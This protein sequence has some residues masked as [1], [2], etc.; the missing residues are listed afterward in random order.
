MRRTRKVTPEGML[1]KLLMS[2]NGL[3]AKELACRIGKAEATVCD[4]I[5]GKNKSRKTLNLILDV[6]REEQESEKMKEFL[7]LF[8]EQFGE[9]DI[10]DAFEETDAS[11]EPVV[12]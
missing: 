8:K 2:T 3:T 5:S 9:T 10:L 12:E 11:M 1:I 7:Q 4:V 6:L